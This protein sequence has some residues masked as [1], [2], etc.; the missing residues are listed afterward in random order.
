MNIGIPCKDIVL[1]SIAQKGID[2]TKKDAQKIADAC[3]IKKESVMRWI[4][5]VEKNEIIIR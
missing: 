2:Q 3:F 1:T 5:K 4:R